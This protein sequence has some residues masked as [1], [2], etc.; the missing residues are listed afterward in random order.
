MTASF[1]RDPVILL[2]DVARMMRIKF[3]QRAR[4]RGM[5]R[6]QWIILARLD[7]QPGLSQNELAALC[8]VEPISVARLIDRLERRGVLERRA[9]PNDRRVWRLHNLPA[10]QPILE[11]ITAYR[12]ALI[13]G[14]DD[15]IGGDAREALVQA[16]L[17]IKTFLTTPSAPDLVAART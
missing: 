3:D 2:H 9:D 11:E 1:D 12:E 17:G 6:A 15:Q 7:H 13:A 8:E 16:L 10:A 5:T 14:I 4:A